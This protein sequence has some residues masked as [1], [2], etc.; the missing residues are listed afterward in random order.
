M[1]KTIL[2]VVLAAAAI[3][4]QP[5]LAQPPKP[6]E[7]AVPAQQE[8]PNIEEFDRQVAQMHENLKEMDA[9][10]EKIRQTKDPE[11][12]RHLLQKYWGAMQHEMGMMHGMLTASGMGCCMGGGPGHGM[13]G[14]PGMGQ[15]KM[16]GRMMG[17]GQMQGYYSN[18]TPEQ[19]KQRQYMTDQYLRMQQMMMEHMML[20]QYWVGPHTSAVQK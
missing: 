15:G 2:L 13:M 12:R 4:A 6:P 5:L 16:G 11:E 9:L 7:K 3:T 18:L 8:A 17:W 1:N 20:H 14:K 10:M 19:M